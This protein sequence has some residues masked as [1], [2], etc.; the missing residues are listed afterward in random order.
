MYDL[1]IVRDLTMSHT[2][3]QVEPMTAI[4]WSSVLACLR[5]RAEVWNGDP[6]PGH[7]ATVEPLYREPLEYNSIL[8][9]K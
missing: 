5:F 4:D 8:R 9:R 6:D 2:S 7:G 1:Y 3:L